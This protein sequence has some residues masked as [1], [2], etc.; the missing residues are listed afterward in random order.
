[1][2]FARRVE[3]R[4]HEP[5]RIA[6]EWLISW[7]IRVAPRPAALFRTHFVR[8]YFR[9][10]HA[11]GPHQLT[12]FWAIFDR[13]H[14]KPFILTVIFIATYTIMAANSTRILEGFHAACPSPL[15]GSQ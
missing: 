11:A 10:R 8:G 15:R 9:V 1:M 13:F 14:A 2:T 7:V 4:L 5:L 12:N 3:Y 6:R